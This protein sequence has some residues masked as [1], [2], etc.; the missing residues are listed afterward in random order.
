[1]LSD[2]QLLHSVKELAERY[3]ILYTHTHTQNE[4]NALNVYQRRGRV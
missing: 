1:M 2:W 4:G 3:R